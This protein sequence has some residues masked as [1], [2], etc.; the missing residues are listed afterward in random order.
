SLA[1]LAGGVMASYP[2]VLVNVA[3]RERHPDAAGELADEI[4]AAEAA[5]GEE[6]R[7]LVRASGTE[8]LVRVMVE[9]ATDDVARR[10]AEHL[11][12]TVRRRWS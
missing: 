8:P 6:G 10:V 9:A 7:V 11:A 4:A 3:V 2:Q 12:E 1:S 5:L